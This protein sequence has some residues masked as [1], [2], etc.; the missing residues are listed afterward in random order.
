MEM[1]GVGFIGVE[2]RFATDRQ[3]DASRTKILRIKTER[4]QQRCRY[5]SLTL[6]PAGFRRQK[7]L[8]K[9]CTRLADRLR[10]R[11]A[12]SISPE[13]ELTQENRA[14]FIFTLVAFAKAT[15]AALA[16]SENRPYYVYDSIC[17]L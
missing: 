4:Q 8:E 2:Y 14:Q 16:G 6:W 13:H 15:Q 7:F 3:H 10:L 11:P 5:I 1:C 17:N 9:S 12:S